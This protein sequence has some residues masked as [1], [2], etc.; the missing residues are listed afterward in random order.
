MPFIYKSVW[1]QIGVPEEWKISDDDLCVTF[2][3]ADPPAILQI[4]AAAKEEGDVTIDDLKEFAAEK[5]AP[6]PPTSVKLGNLNGFAVE[7][8]DEGM[9]CR[10]WWLY[11]GNIAIFITLNAEV[12]HRDCLTQVNKVLGTIERRRRT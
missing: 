1:W 12:T 5:M 2:N 8:V 9:W 3:I 10:Q 7:S 6:I 11:V 4:S